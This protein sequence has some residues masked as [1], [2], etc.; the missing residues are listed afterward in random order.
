MKPRKYTSLQKATAQQQATHREISYSLQLPSDHRQTFTDEE[1]ALLRPI[2]ETLAMLDGNAFFGT[3]I[4][5][6]ITGMDREWYEQYL[7]EAWQ[8]WNGNAGLEG[9][10]GLTGWGSEH[11]LRQDNITL[12]GLWDQYHLAL[13]LVRADAH[14]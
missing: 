11:K 4:G 6:P 12:R 8:V 2:A 14:G 1:K 3:K 5:D 7:P 9:W 13:K 10:A